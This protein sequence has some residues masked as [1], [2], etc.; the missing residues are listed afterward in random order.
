[1]IL[2]LPHLTVVTYWLIIEVHKAFCP[3]FPSVCSDENPCRNIEPPEHEKVEKSTK[4]IS[5]QIRKK[6]GNEK[7]RGS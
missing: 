3:A 7:Q 6:I 4:N 1:M 5:G 2:P